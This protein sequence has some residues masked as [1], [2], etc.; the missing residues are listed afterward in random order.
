MND[1]AD[2]YIEEAERIWEADKERRKKGIVNELR[3][4][5]RRLRIRF[6][7]YSKEAK[8]L[9]GKIIP[10]VERMCYYPPSYRGMVEI[11]K[12]LFHP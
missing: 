6:G 5:S 2:E 10:Y 3:S 11:F 7:R 9:D 1:W 12:E 8:Y 4:V